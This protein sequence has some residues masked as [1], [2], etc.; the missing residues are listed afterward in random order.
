MNIETLTYYENTYLKNFEIELNERK[1]EDALIE[2]YI[3]HVKDYFYYLVSKQI[4]IEEGINYIDDYYRNVFCHEAYVTLGKLERSY[5]SLKVFFEWR[6]VDLSSLDKNI[7]EWKNILNETQQLGELEPSEDHLEIAFVI[8]N[9]KRENETYLA[10]FQEYLE[11]YGVSTR[12]CTQYLSQAEFYLNEY[13]AENR[14]RHMVHGVR[15]MHGFFMDY[16]YQCMF[17]ST[18]TL[19]ERYIKSIRMFYRC[20]HDRKCIDDELYA[21]F[22]AILKENKSRWIDNYRENERIDR[23]LEESFIENLEK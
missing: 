11:T 9:I 20:M 18:E 14:Q 12:L 16:F 2:T 4:T 10:I 1:L 7:E 17:Y 6:G 22:E 3:T 21:F 13:L 15:D 8:E 5:T 23:K 19:M